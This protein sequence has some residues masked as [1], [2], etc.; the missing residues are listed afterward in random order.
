VVAIIFVLRGVIFL[1][2]TVIVFILMVISPLAIMAGLSDEFKSYFYQWLGAMQAM[3]IAPLPAAICFRLVTTYVTSVP[4]PNAD[5]A[6]FLLKLIYIASFLSIGGILMFKIAGQAGEMIFGVV[7]GAIGALVGVMAGGGSAVASTSASNSSGG[8][9]AGNNSEGNS[10]SGIGQ[11]Q[12]SYYNNG[13]GGAGGMAIPR[14]ASASGNGGSS[15]GGGWSSNSGGEVGAASFGGY[16]MQQRQQAEQMT[17]AIRSLSETLTAS[18]YESALDKLY[19]GPAG[20]GPFHNYEANRNTQSLLH[21]AGRAAGITNAPHVTFVPVGRR[22]AS[23]NSNPDLPGGESE[24]ELPDNVVPHQPEP[25]HTPEVTTTIPPSSR[26]LQGQVVEEIERSGLSE[27]APAP[28]LPGPAW[29]SPLPV[30][31]TVVSPSLPP[32]APRLTSGSPTSQAYQGAVVYVGPASASF[33]SGQALP[34]PPPPPQYDTGGTIEAREII[35][36]IEGSPNAVVIS[37]VLTDPYGNED[38]WFDSPN[39]V[40][41]S[42]IT[43]QSHSYSQT[44]IAAPVII[45]PPPVVEPTSK[46]SHSTPA[47]TAPTTSPG[48]DENVKVSE[49]APPN[50]EKI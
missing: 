46:V 45:T 13:G 38:S 19:R 3:L 17:R 33:G 28:R 42:S 26:P 24:N 7:V 50:G 34:L 31:T 29:P 22:V 20:G 1:L 12:L 43:D 10:G 36:P 25:P 9:K 21:A 39:F 48:A 49:F 2:R 41:E 18:R 16:D 32:A 14:A 11:G 35:T 23:S 5:P 47:D 40:P 37:N 44:E 30:T 27:G 6:G 15:G 8:A 4:N